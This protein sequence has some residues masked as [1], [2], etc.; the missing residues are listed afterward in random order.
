MAERFKI[1]LTIMSIN[2]EKAMTFNDL[3][4]DSITSEALTFSKGAFTEN[5]R[6]KLTVKS[7]EL[8]VGELPE[9]EPTE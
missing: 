1:D 3:S 5:K 8:F 9:E 4:P 2:G 6:I 7:D